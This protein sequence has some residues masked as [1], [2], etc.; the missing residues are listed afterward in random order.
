MT[1]PEPLKKDA[2]SQAEPLQKG[3]SAQAPTTRP[4]AFT[5]AIIEKGKNLRP[6]QGVAQH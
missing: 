3:P 5:E 2:R 4:S 1:N 6:S